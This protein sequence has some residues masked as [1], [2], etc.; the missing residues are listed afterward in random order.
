MSTIEVVV[1]ALVVLNIV[2]SI[3]LLLVLRPKNRNKAK[4]LK[5]V[6][7]NLTKKANR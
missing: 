2:N 3:L 1:I 5:K 7:G 6:V 4:A